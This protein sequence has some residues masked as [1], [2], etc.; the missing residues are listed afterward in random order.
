MNSAVNHLSAL[1][2]SRL[3]YHPPLAPNETL[4]AR[5][6]D[7]RLHASAGP[8]TVISLSGSVLG[9]NGSRGGTGE[10]RR[11]QGDPGEAVARSCPCRQGHSGA[12]STRPQHTL[13]PP[14]TSKNP[15]R[16]FDARVTPASG[17]SQSRV[18]KALE[19]NEEVSYTER[20]RRSC[21]SLSVGGLVETNQ[22]GACSPPGNPAG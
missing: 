4:V 1:S 7:G 13:A 8:R 3:L 19:R 20:H 15:D 18:A 11:G 14:A 22:P 10:R 6:L 16:L 21:R 2:S 5:G 9:V 17:S 12:A